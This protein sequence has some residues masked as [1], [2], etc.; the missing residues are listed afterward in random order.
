MEQILL[1]AYVLLSVGMIGLILLQQGKGADAGASFGAGASQTVFGSGGSSNALTRGTAILATLFFIA[2]VS[3]A[4][5]ARH[6]AEA[7]RDGD[8]PIPAAVESRDL[9]VVPAPAAQTIPS[10]AAD[11]PTAAPAGAEPA[12]AGVVEDIPAGK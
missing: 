11:V 10:L 9:P 1:V 2:S 3:M 6:K 7:A 5:I 4:V 8:I 12:A